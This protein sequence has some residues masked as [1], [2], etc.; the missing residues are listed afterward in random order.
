MQALAGDVLL[1]SKV[2]MPTWLEG[3][4]A[5]RRNLIALANGILDLDALLAGQN[6]VLLPHTPRWFSPSCLP[7]GFDPHA[8]CPR[9]MAFLQRNLAGNAGKNSLLQQWTGYLL[10]PDTSM[11]KSLM[12]VGE[13]ANGKSVVCAVLTALLGVENVSAVPLELF[14]DKFRLAGTLGKLA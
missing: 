6:T 1:P 14:G 8:D 13:G 2:A 7:Y 3:E 11:Q 10:T 9:W 5:T 12:M 4:Q